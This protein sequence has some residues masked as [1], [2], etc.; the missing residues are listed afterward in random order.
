[1]LPVLNTAPAKASP[2]CAVNNRCVQ[3]GTVGLSTFLAG[4]GK[5]SRASRGVKNGRRAGK[6]ANYSAAISTLGRH[7]SLSWSCSAGY[8]LFQHVVCVWLPL[9]LLISSM[10]QWPHGARAP[11]LRRPQT[12]HAR[13]TLTV[14]FDGNPVRDKRLNTRNRHLR[15]HRGF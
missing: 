4:A 3:P 13:V 11:A 5:R 8:A 7:D 14:K 15:N 6:A 1:M 10:G 9:S 12:K 2:A